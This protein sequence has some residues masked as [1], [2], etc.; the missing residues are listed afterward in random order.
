MSRRR[1]TFT[2]DEAAE[3]VFDFDCGELSSSESDE[4]ILSS[5]EEERLDEGRHTSD[6]DISSDDRNRDGGV[7]AGNDPGH[8]DSEEV[9]G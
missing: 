1:R 7:D 8:E 9:V 3:A 4:S 2:P 5:S 6:E